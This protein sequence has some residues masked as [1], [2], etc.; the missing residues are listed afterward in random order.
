MTCLDDLKKAKN[1]IAVSG[2]VDKA[3]ATYAALKGNYIHCLITDEFIAEKILRLH[4]Q[5]KK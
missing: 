1:V 4:E 2:G 3:H 5:D